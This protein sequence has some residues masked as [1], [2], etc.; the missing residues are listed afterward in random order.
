MYCVKCGS[1]IDSNDKTC[2]FCG[3]TISN[4]VS[5]AVAGRN[6]HTPLANTGL[7]PPYCTNCGESVGDLKICS[8]CH[9]KTK[10]NYKKYCRY[11][12]GAI[13]ENQKCSEC[14]SLARASV[15]ESIA[16]FFISAIM[17]V[18][19][20]FALSLIRFKMTAM[21][22]AL[23]V[24]T[25][26]IHALIYRKKQIR[27]FKTKLFHHKAKKLI[28]T[29]IYMSVPIGLAASLLV[30]AALDGS[31]IGE[32]SRVI[33]YGENCIRQ[34]L[35]NPSSMK[36]H[37]SNITDSFKTDD[38]YTYYKIL[39]DYSAQNGF[40][41]YVRKTGEIYVYS[42]AYG[43]EQISAITYLQKKGLLDS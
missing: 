40:G 6:N 25:L 37:S 26:T 27:K 22:L 15:I 43:T 9:L 18:C 29:L 16:R 35:K 38:G 31:G 4:V 7:T 28:L 36:I 19:Y 12:G 3:N 34:T 24:G 2:S 20:I 8:H 5:E 11:C 1:R 10:K 42:S 32:N 30:G 33:A 39:I 14:G 17:L 41:G 23:L 21:G 13:G